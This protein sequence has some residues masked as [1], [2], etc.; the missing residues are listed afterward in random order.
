MANATPSMRMLTFIFRCTVLPV[1]R[2]KKRVFLSLKVDLIVLTKNTTTMAIPEHQGM[3]EPLSSRATDSDPPSFVENQKKRS[4]EVESTE[5]EATVQRVHSET[6]R[7]QLLIERLSISKDAHGK[8]V[9]EIARLRADSKKNYNKAK[10]QVRV[11]QLW[12]TAHD[13]MKTDYS[14]EKASNDLLRAQIIELEGKLPMISK[15]ASFPTC[16]DE[17]HDVA[18]TCAAANAASSGT[19]LDDDTVDP[20][21]SDRICD[22][23]DTEDVVRLESI[24]PEDGIVPGISGATKQHAIQWNAMFYR[25][26]LYTKKYGTSVVKKKIDESLYC[27]ALLQRNLRKENNLRQDRVDKL[28]EIEYVDSEVERCRAIVAEGLVVGIPEHDAKDARWNDVYYMLQRHKHATGTFVVKK[29]STLRLH[30]WACTQRH[31]AKAQ[32]LAPNRLEKLIAIDFIKVGDKL[33]TN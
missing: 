29:R 1:V 31:R 14:A 19:I 33:G 4:R 15:V 25:L 11:A 21:P 18:D 2:R 23:A 30:E 3:R 28:Q 5:Y 13:A 27:W 12:K 8:A 32:C 9:I 10:D 16:D 17:G 24:P 22:G 26:Q 20:S 6:L 7:E